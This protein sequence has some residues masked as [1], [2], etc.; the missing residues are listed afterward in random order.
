M[1]ELFD[2]FDE[3]EFEEGFTVDAEIDPELDGEELSD[4]EY[5]E[6]EEAKIEREIDEMEARHGIIV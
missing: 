2:E 5:Y 3:E 6:S 1:I 4:I